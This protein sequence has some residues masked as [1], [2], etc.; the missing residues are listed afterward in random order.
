M[1]FLLDP[2]MEEGQKPTPDMCSVPTVSHGDTVLP[3][4]EIVV[5]N[6][7]DVI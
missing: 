1:L 7:N 4:Q 6:F 2:S 3:S 5:G